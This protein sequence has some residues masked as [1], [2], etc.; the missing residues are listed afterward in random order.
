[1]Q[2]SDGAGGGGG[3]WRDSGTAAVR[4]LRCCRLICTERGSG[5]EL[6]APLLH[7]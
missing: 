7:K 1:V 5:M 2:E 3:G 4:A 6:F